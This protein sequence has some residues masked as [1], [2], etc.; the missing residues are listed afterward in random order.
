MQFDE[1]SPFAM[2]VSII[3]DQSSLKVDARTSLVESPTAVVPLGEA[4]DGL[5]IVLHVRRRTEVR[6]PVLAALGLGAD[7]DVPPELEQ[8][9]AALEHAVVRYARNKGVEVIEGELCYRTQRCV[10]ALMGRPL[11][12]QALGVNAPLGLVGEGGDGGGDGPG[13]LAITSAMPFAAQPDEAI[14]EVIKTNDHIALPIEGGPP[15]VVRVRKGQEPRSRPLAFERLSAFPSA[16]YHLR[17]QLGLEEALDLDDP[18]KYAIS[19]AHAAELGWSVSNADLCRTVVQLARRVHATHLEGRIHGDLKPANV[20]VNDGG[21]LPIDSLDVPIGGI[22]TA[23]TPGWAA[24][25]QILALPATAGTDVYALGLILA[26]VLSAAIYGEERSFIVPAGGESRRRVRLLS[27]PRVFIDPTTSQHD[28]RLRRAWEDHIR[29]C[30]A[31]EQDRRLAS[32][33]EVADRVEQLLAESQPAGR[34]WLLAGPGL[35]RRHVE[36]S[37]KIQPCWVLED[38]DT[39]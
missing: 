8:A 26:R 6:S 3:G 5:P 25:E 24:P 35:L 31:L 1:V 12:A 37:G 32:A 17:D 4:P 34:R 14:D 21:A 27:D 36:I 19:V 2:F 15:R 22:C 39:F 11:F 7:D 20:I 28:D 23:A 29:S 33:A 30:I 18:G 9:L 16:A 10:G 13:R 38:G